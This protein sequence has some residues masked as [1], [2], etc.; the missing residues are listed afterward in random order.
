MVN[1][2]AMTSRPSK[3]LQHRRFLHAVREWFRRGK[4]STAANRKLLSMPS[5]RG[6]SDGARFS[7][8]VSVAALMVS[9][10][11]PLFVTFVGLSEQ[12][13]VLSPATL[14]ERLMVPENPA[15]VVTVIVSVAVPP[16]LI[17]RDGLP[18]ANVKP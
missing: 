10:E 16:L 9:V 17:V 4:I 13:V 5:P 6:E 18:A 2:M 11:V 12:V 14:H 7:R 1:I 8:E 15:S 3:L